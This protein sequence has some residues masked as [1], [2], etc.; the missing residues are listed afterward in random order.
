MRRL[1]IFSCLLW[2][3]TSSPTDEVLSWSEWKRVHTVTYEDPEEDLRRQAIY[4]ANVETIVAHNSNPDKSYTM[5]VNRFSALT[6]VEFSD[7]FRPLPPMPPSER[8]DAY[9]EVP[10]A[11]A[12]DAIDWR[13]KGAVT[14]VKDQGGCG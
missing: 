11:G 1:T 13:T 6:P 2:A 5:G 10:A 4:R 9:L 7:L 12:S 8:H 3:A 14:P